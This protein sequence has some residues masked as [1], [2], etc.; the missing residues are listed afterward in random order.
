MQNYDS[1]GFLMI[2]KRS[3]ISRI[4]MAQIAPIPFYGQRKLAIENFNIRPLPPECVVLHLCNAMG[5][6]AVHLRA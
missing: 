5:G 4:E 3:G 2:P 6:V 1:F